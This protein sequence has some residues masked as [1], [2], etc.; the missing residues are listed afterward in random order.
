MIDLLQPT[1]KDLEHTKQY[2]E[3]KIK[4]EFDS[5]PEY[6]FINRFL[7]KKLSLDSNRFYI[8]RFGRHSL[9][10]N[11]IQNSKVSI[12]FEGAVSPKDACFDFSIALSIEDAN[13]SER[14]LLNLYDQYKHDFSNYLK[15]FKIIE[16]EPVIDSTFDF[17]ILSNSLNL[18][19]GVYASTEEN[20]YQFRR[21]FD[22]IMKPFYLNANY[23]SYYILHKENDNE[24]YNEEKKELFFAYLYFSSFVAYHMNVTDFH[25]DDFLFIHNF[26]DLTNF[27]IRVLYQLNKNNKPDFLDLYV[28]DEN[29]RLTDDSKELLSINF[30]I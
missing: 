16:N 1:L 14:D 23:K 10:F 7:L 26:Y 18:Y 11:D 8:Q 4:S 9:H 5:F 2:N 21:N 30:K 29:G 6:D 13:D 17:S 28:F 27:G 24:E 3:I 15:Q 19:K 25:Y 20:K 22:L 12:V